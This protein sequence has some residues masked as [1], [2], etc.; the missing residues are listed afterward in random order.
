VA[1][2][3]LID[4]TRC[5]GCGACQMACQA[6]YGFPEKEESELSATARTTVE[7][8]GD[9]YVRRMCMHCD[10]PSCVSVCPVG[11]LQKTAEGPVIYD[12]KACMGC[13]Y[14][15]VACPFEVP[16]YEWS[17]LTPR[18]QKC[19]MCYHRITKGQVPACVEACPEEAV[20]F[21]DK[22]QLLAEARRR[23]VGSPDKYVPRIYGER[24]IGGTSVLFLAAV[25]FEQLAFKV[26]LGDQPM[27]ELTW[28]AL[29]KIPEVV[30]LGGAFMMGLFWI[31]DRRNKRAREQTGTEGTQQ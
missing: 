7:E 9:Y 20:T 14:C 13:R 2:A 3:M 6:E 23:I 25:P 12:E 10:T 17:S 31:V 28:A 29:S 1:Y 5:A 11:A 8:Q 30:T 26:K 4:T 27:P 19:T 18:I 22:K 24:I 16:R 21:G 15:M